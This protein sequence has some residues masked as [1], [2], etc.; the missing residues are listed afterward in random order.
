M[1]TRIIGWMVNVP[2]FSG[3]SGSCDWRPWSMASSSCREG[4]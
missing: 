2:R 4:D 1:R 3:T